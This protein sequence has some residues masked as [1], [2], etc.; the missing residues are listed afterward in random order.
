M[1]CDVMGNRQQMCSIAS[2]RQY[3]NVPMGD[4]LPRLQGRI[5]YGD[6]RVISSAPHI[7]KFWADD[8]SFP[9]KSH[10]LWFL[11][12]NM[13]WGV[14]PA[15]T[16]AQALVAKV[17]RADIWRAAAA[18][19]GVK[20]PASDSRGVETFFDGKAFDPAH[21]GAWLAA[22]PIKKLS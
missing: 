6:G 12:E 19:H 16:N 22:Q 17:N 21:P 13:R 9:F 11:T 1:W 8:A 5:D 3:I 15:R 10:D 2:A 7:M 20:G 14:L 18:M 4:I